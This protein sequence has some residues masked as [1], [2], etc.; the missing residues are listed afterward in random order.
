MTDN[1][2]TSGLEVRSTITSSGELTITLD[3]VP[4]PEPAADEVVVRVE[5]T[6][7]NPSDFGVL[8]GP[9]NVTTLRAVGTAERPA[10]RGEVAPAGLAAVRGRL[11]QSLRVGNEGAG[12]VVRAGSATQALIGKV[13][14]T[15]TPGMYAQFRVAKLADCIVMPEGTAPRDAAS[16]FINPLTVLGMIETMRREGHVGLVHTA[17]ASNVGQMLVRLCNAEGIPLVN[18][19][20][21]AEQARSLAAIGARHVVDSSSPAFTAALT[22]AIAETGAML[23]FDA[24]GGGTMAATLLHCMEAAALRKTS[25]YLRYGTPTPKQVYIYGALDPRTTEVPR[26]FGL[27]WGIG[28]WLMTWC[29]Q[30]I[31]AEAEARLRERVAREIHTIFATTYGSEVGLAE[32]VD[33]AVI[34]AANARA[35]GAKILINP[36]RRA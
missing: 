28:G 2:A 13:V 14:T 30:K 15:R 10:V 4:I 16:A 33:P 17:A 11:D 26:T 20:R 7:L 36:N 22:D 23:A 1:I 8:V 35:T 31:G 27:A 32:L 12:V 25:G 34:A 29:M 18:V 6:P 24:I 9:A 5:A 3:E 21:S 19:V